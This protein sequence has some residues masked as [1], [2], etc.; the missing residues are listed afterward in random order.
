MSSSEWFYYVVRYLFNGLCL[1]VLLFVSV[2]FVPP[3]LGL[4]CVCVLLAPC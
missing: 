1:S 4:L 3:T 2:A